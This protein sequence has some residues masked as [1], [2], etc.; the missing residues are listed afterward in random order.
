MDTTDSTKILR[1]IRTSLVEMIVSFARVLFFW[2]PGGDRAKGQ[3]L[4]A[5]HPLFILLVL[6]MF[7]MLPVQHPLRFV[8]MIA[9]ILTS[10]SQWLLGGCILTRAEQI[11]TGEKNT[12][13]DP[14]LTLAHIQVNRDTRIAATIASGTSIT[15][16][17]IWDVVCHSFIHRIV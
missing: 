11:L 16:I 9:A 12:I 2:L 5:C 3:A 6:A 14:F 17:L 4:M 15:A 1:Q 8:I 13:L 7:F 10:A